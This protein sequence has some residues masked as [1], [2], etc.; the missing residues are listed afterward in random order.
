MVATLDARG[1]V[2]IFHLQRN[3]YEHLRHIGSAGS[4]IA[5]SSRRK[6]ELFVAAKDGS[7]RVCVALPLRELVAPSM[8]A[9]IF[10]FGFV[11]RWTLAWILSVDRF[12]C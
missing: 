3:R 4:A 5:F 11:F 7:V 2:V 8:P 12:G 10:C 9:I 1:H 6:N